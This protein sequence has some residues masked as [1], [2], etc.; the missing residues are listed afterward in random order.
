M[1]KA[2]QAKFVA[3]FGLKVPVVQGPM[4]NIS[5]PK[6]VAAVANAGGLGILPIWLNTVEQTIATINATQALTTNPFAVNLR[7]DLV[8][9]DLV[10]AALDSGITIIHLFWGDPA[11]S[12]PPV[13]HAGAS[14]IATVWDHDSAQAALD[15]GASALIAQGVEAGG[16]VYGDTPLQ[17]LLPIVLELAKNTPVIAAGG[18]ATN[19]DAINMLNR[20]AAGILWGTRFVLS[21]E[22]DAHEDYKRALIESD[23]GETARSMCF[24]DFWSNAPHR[25]LANSTFKAWD[26]AGQPSAGNRPGE[27]DII[28]HAPG[29]IE[30]PRYH[31]MPPALAMSGEIEASAMYAGTGASQLSDCLPA[32]EIIERFA[33]AL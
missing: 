30:I 24:D 21:T 12:M 16:H 13:K 32:A 33:T 2:S 23:E 11:L 1:T 9:L 29:G 31:A 17:K 6:L 26:A 3:D 18:C 10:K 14:M 19:V 8:Q 7:A 4:G 27:G 15:A 5:G 25:T 28:L 20:G 22:S